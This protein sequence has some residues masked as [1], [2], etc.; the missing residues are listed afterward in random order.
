MTIQLD[1]SKLYGFKIESRKE[2]QAVADSAKLG[3]KLG[4][5][6]GK[7][8]GLKTAKLSAKLGLKVGL[9]TIRA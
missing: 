8:I 7:K 2:T 6:V 9:K 5:K 1:P 3:S 4:H